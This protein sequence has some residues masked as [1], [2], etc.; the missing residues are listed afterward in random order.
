M[1]NRFPL[2][3]LTLAAFV[4][5]AFFA[6]PL[7]GQIHHDTKSLLDADLHRYGVE[8]GR[9]KY[10][11]SGS[12]TGTE[13]LMFKDWG[14]REKSYEST[15]LKALGMNNQTTLEVFRDGN[16]V[17]S[18]NKAGL[19]G[20]KASDRHLDNVIAGNPGSEGPVLGLLAIEDKEVRKT[21]KDTHLGKP[22]D[23]YE[24]KSESRKIWVW[25]GIVLRSEQKWLDDRILM[26]ATFIELDYKV[27]D[28][29]VTLPANVTIH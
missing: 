6:N 8:E 25:E 21:G 18:R 5:G 1:K 11:Y 4:L 26:E 9:I 28:E 7:S 19:M 20:S 10:E 23:V 22:C 3:L 17:Y 15:R 27:D 29:D 13:I 24:I 12:K 2:S 14:W 16:M